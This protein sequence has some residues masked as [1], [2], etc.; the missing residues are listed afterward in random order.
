MP[1]DAGDHDAWGEREA[2]LEPE[3][4]LF[5][6]QVFPPVPHGVFGDE[7]GDES[8]VTCTPSHSLISSNEETNR[9]RH[10]VEAFLRLAEELQR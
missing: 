6:Q 4:R 2:A 7:D 3:R 1:G 5:V 9:A 10:K 8:P